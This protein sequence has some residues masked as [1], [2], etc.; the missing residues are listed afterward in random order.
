M[1][2]AILSKDG[3]RSVSFI[4]MLIDKLYRPEVLRNGDARFA[5]MVSYMDCASDGFDHK[6]RVDGDE[7]IVTP[8]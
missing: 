3:V 4:P 8:Q 5:D 1:V 7:V 6:F 2:K